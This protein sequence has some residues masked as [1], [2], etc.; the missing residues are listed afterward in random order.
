MS[1]LLTFGL[2]PT[3]LPPVPVGT[4]LKRVIVEVM[5]ADETM[6]SLIGTN[7]YPG[8][9]PQSITPGSSALA[10]R[11]SSGEH[12]VHLRGGAGIATYRMEFESISPTVAVTEQVRDRIK[13]LF[14]A[15][16]RDYGAVSI[17]FAQL[18]DESDDEVTPLPGSDRW[19]FLKRFTV[20]YKVRESLPTWS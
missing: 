17:C 7:Y 14:N 15:L 20:R 18:E 2:G 3:G 1:R 16:I 4:D 9:I 10:Y 5:K 13:N 19:T 12:D 11:F 6:L 8:H